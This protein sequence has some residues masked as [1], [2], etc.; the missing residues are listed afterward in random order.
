MTLPEIKVVKKYVEN[1]DEF[2]NIKF[3]SSAE[4]SQLSPKN[5]EEYIDA[6]VSTCIDLDELEKGLQEEQ[7]LD[8]RREGSELQKQLYETCIE[9]NPDLKIETVGLFPA[10]QE[11]TQRQN[12]LHGNFLSLEK[13]L[14]KRVIGQRQAISLVVKTL[15]RTESG[16][17][18]EHR[19]RGNFLF[20]GRTG[21]GKTELAKIL[22]KELEEY[23]FLHI[24]GSEFE[25][26]HEY[27]KLLGAPP[28]YIG[29]DHGG[30]LEILNKEPR[31]VILWDEIEKAH[32]AVHNILLQIL[33]E[34]ETGDTRGKKTKY[35]HAINILTSNTGVTEADESE[36]RISFETDTNLDRGEYESIIKKSLERN[37]KPEFLNRL[38]AICVFNVLGAQ[39]CLAITAVQLDEI[40][41]KLSKRGVDLTYTE[42]VVKKIVDQAEYRRYGAREIKRVIAA[43]VEDRIA[44]LMLRKDIKRVAVD[45][46]RRFTFRT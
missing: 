41:R 37:F 25:S 2:I 14:N 10:Q 5:K 32:P 34:G 29:H 26:R 8:L 11:S 6:V 35:N 9:V 44:D 21:I 42:R 12:R 38:D 7:R 1:I 31:T 36:N 22:A 15:K 33:D 23:K 43:T 28:G 20:A 3:Q 46:H 30:L 40:A 18:D 19:P 17:R 45:Y 13:T 27:T 16:L 39:E 4:I 24:H